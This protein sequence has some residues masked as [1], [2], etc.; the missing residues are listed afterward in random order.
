[1][2]AEEKKTI[3]MLRQIREAVENKSLSLEQFP[4][5]D[6]ANLIDATLGR[7]F[8]GM[9]GG[10]NKKNFDP[11]IDC[12][13]K[14]IQR[15]V[16]QRDIQGCVRA[17]LLLEEQY[18]CFDM[19]LTAYKGQKY[20][21]QYKIIAIAAGE[22]YSKLQYYLH[23]NVRIP[24][25]VEVEKD[26]GG[27]GVVFTT[28][29][30]SQIE[31]QQPE[32][33]NM[34]WDYI[35]F[36]K[37]KEKL[38]TKE[39]V[40]QYRDFNVE[41]CEDNRILFHMCMLKAHELLPEYDYSIWVNPA[42]KI[43]GD[44]ELFLASYGRNVSFLAFPSYVTDDVYEI[45]ETGLHSDEE[46]IKMRKKRLQY[47]KEGY[48]CHYGMISDNIIIRNHRDEK[49]CDVMETWW[50]EAMECG[51]LWNFGFNYAAWKNDFKFAVCDAFVEM[52]FYLKNM[53]C[54]LEVKRNE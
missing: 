32:Y 36:T 45:M 29:L 38:G 4:T 15:C 10:M 26:W 49:M 1:M 6:L 48:P 46:N 23:Q 12:L 14:M 53:V 43:V 13:L 39:G 3:D 51:R 2:T 54:D 33:I 8:L 5:E 47:E 34:N 44:L 7:E 16:E 42:Y 31:L 41:G 18:R 19:I 35:C 21:E 40:W 9:T 50:K 11:L 30:F 52:N 27:K 37:D 25:N 28:T 22:A 24:K 17:L 20:V